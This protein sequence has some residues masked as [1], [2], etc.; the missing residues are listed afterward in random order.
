MAAT[1]H[2]SQSSEE[3]W[4]EIPN[5]DEINR[6][7]VEAKT[8]TNIY[9]D[10]LERIFEF[11]DLKS[12][13]NLAQTCKQ[14]Q[15]AAA[16]KFG[17][18]YGKGRIVISPYPIYENNYIELSKHPHPYLNR[19]NVRGLETCLPFLRCFGAK[20]QHLHFILQSKNNY[21]DQYV[22][23]YCADTLT[24]IE[25]YNH[26]RFLFTKPFKNVEVLDLYNT[27]SIRNEL[28]NLVKWFPK[29][30]HLKLDHV[31]NN[32]S[33]FGVRFPT[34]EEVTLFVHGNYLHELLE[35]Q[36]I[37]DMNVPSIQTTLTT[38]NA[39][40]FLHANPQLCRVTFEA[41]RLE[42]TLTTLL[43]MMSKNS[44]LLA[45]HVHGKSTFVT[46]DETKRL[47]SEHRSIVDLDLKDYVFTSDSVIH[48]I[49][50]LNSLRNIS[51]RMQNLVEY[52]RLLNQKSNEWRSNEMN[53]HFD[54]AY[55]GSIFVSLK[56]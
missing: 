30:R 22:N 56:R 33:P 15:I 6:T 16:T 46:M 10:C 36:A 4:K 55:D 24:R 19:I 49:R 8:I 20:V 14:L 23:Q 28:P 48:I 9:Y 32:R 2:H 1:N 44:S 54:M 12:L 27:I 18:E 37:I 41:W 53:P 31:F 38:E 13:L 47:T 25:F 21:A 45:L 29:L 26:D 34:L 11:L 50:Q 51:V 52:V 5:E 42:L 35:H 39:M 40:D 43:N 17:H 3:Q 7:E